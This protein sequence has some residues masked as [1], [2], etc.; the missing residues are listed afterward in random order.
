MIFLL[1]QLLAQGQV[2]EADRL[3]RLLAKADSDT[4]RVVLKAHLAHAFLFFNSDT[5]MTLCE[6]ALGEARKINFPKGE[7]MALNELGSALRLRGDLPKSLQLSLRALEIS[8]ANKDREGQ[9][10]SMAYIG[11]IYMQLEEHKQALRYLHHAKRITS[12]I[13]IQ[14]LAVSLIGDI[15][16][17]MNM[18]DSAMFF[19]QNAYA[20]LENIPIGPLKS[21]VPTRLGVVYDKLGNHDKALIYY[22]SALKNAETLGD[23]LNQGRIQYRIG[24]YYYRQH[25]RDS[26]L[27]YARL[28]FENGK[29]IN[30]Q[31]T[32]LYSS[33]LLTKL[34]KPT[35]LDSALHYLEVNMANRDILYGPEKLQQVQLLV[36][37]EQ[38]RQ[39][40][41][42]QQRAQS[43]ERFRRIGLISA[44]FVILVI[45]VLI[46]RNYK[47]QLKAN[48]LLNE[49]NNKIL[50]QRSALEK[51][52]V[53][54]KDTQTQL[55]EKERIAAL[56]QQQLKIQQVRNKIAAELHDDIGSTLSSIH[57][58]SEAA[59]KQIHQ[60]S[61]QAIPILEKIES[62]S[63][64]IMQSMS[65]IVWS[66]QPKNDDAVNLIDKIFSFAKELLSARNI[67][68]RFE[69]PEDFKS[70][71]LAMEVRR[72]IHLMIKE[73]LNNIV[74]HAHASEVGMHV[75]L[76]D[77]SMTISIHD[78]GCGFDINSPGGNGLKNLRS[79][80]EEIGGTLVMDTRPDNGTWIYLHYTLP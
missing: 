72:N 52:L 64:E 45:A 40:E 26:S 49:Q 50:T 65:E 14:I 47:Q 62:S 74:K 34:Y 11:S 30:H 12:R 53:E 73:A 43:D 21:L 68:F 80:A 41:L 51:N 75:S 16:N 1:A 3:K 22:Q 5:A 20:Q 31:L 27:H 76:Q 66:I 25:V 24:E 79:R 9:A 29:R 46:W 36:M 23:L 19:Q 63:E 38:Q 33:S 4:S 15:Y 54:L 10:T 70:F 67:Q 57:L 61:V 56:F 28:A 60:D 7:V 18:L 77:K 32:Q 78:N 39:Q 71:P 37:Q 35:R 13:N 42:L 48:R 17:N 2:V 44:T 59:R 55:V 8:K 69:Y 58:F 6:Q